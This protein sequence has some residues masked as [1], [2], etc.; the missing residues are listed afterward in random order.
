MTATLLRPL[1]GDWQATNHLWFMPGT[2]AFESHTT[3]TVAPAL[4]DFVTLLRYTWSHDGTPHE[5]VMLVRDAADS[6]PEIVWLDSFHTGRKFM[7]LGAGTRSGT[8][9][10]GT[11][12][13]A[14]PEG[15][16]WGWRV[17]LHAESDGAL[18]V[19]HYNIL[20]D[21]LEALAIE[22][23]YTRG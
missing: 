15:P 7:T 16:D 22:A 1:T 18:L 6:P 9:L 19:R 20:P 12:S 10:T 2:P 3:L 11:G 8:V 5:G 23:R 21:G 4:G 13:Y 14:A 17:E